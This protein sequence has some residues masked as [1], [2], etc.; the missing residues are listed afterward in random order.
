M[1]QQA[2]IGEDLIDFMDALGVP[3]R[4]AGRLRLGRPG[5]VH[6]GDPGA[7]AREGAGDHRRLQRPEHRG[8]LAAG[9]RAARAPRTGTSGTSTP[10]AGA[11]GW[12]RTG[13]RSAACCGGMVAGLAL[14]RCQLRAHGAVVPQSRLRADRDPL[15][16]APSRQRPRRSAPGADRA[17]PGHRVRRSPCRRSSCTAAT[18]ASPAPRRPRASWRSSRPGPSGAIVAG[19]GHFMPRERPATVVEAFRALLG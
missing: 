9:L 3:T 18:T 2:A 8:A 5:R 14:R 11:W 15:L 4:G 6:R 1:A 12:S 16:P 10:S 7:R 13:A 19:V 17:A